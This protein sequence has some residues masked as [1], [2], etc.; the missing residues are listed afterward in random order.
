MFWVEN[1]TFLILQGVWLTPLLSLLSP[2]YWVAA[3]E[4]N[5]AANGHTLTK[6]FF[7]REAHVAFATGQLSLGDQQQ[8]VVQHAV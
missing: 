8:R 2:M 1:V 5:G 4:I 3:Y 6:G 7:R